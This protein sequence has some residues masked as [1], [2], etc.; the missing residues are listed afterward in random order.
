MNATINTSER[1]LI[2]AAELRPALAITAR[3]YP[4][5]EDQGVDTPRDVDRWVDRAHTLRRRVEEEEF[6]VE[7]C[8]QVEWYLALHFGLVAL[9]PID[10][11]TP[12]D[13]P[14]GYLTEFFT[15]ASGRAPRLRKL[16]ARAGAE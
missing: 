6:S 4:S 7:R 2:R 12:R 9:E 5:V 8:R 11:M 14:G 10:T 15:R 3:D 16:G 13:V 1:R